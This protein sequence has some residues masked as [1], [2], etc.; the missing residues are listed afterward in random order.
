MHIDLVEEI[1]P[2]DFCHEAFPECSFYLLG[3]VINTSWQFSTVRANTGMPLA[4]F[5]C[6]DINCRN[7]MKET[8][9]DC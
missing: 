9:T 1:L 5:D 2:I 4:L 6:L 3:D 7:C 8:S